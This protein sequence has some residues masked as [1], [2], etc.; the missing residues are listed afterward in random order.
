MH[1]LRYVKERPL[2]QGVF[3]GQWKQILQIE[4]KLVK[5]PNW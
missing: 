2:P 1:T 5:N 3:Q 4:Q